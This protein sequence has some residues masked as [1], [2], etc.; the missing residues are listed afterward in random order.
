MVLT[1]G[2]CVSILTKNRYESMDLDMIH[3]SL[4]K[5]KRK[6]IYDAMGEIGFIEVGRY[7]KHP[8][9]KIFVEFPSVGC[10]W[11]L[12]NC[13]RYSISLF[14]TASFEYSVRT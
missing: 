6:L 1:G 14:V 10:G 8:E 4:L 11:K 9:T 3:T 12:E 13:S 7:F 2:S 5:P